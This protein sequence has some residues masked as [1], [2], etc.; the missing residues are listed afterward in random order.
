MDEQVLL[1]QPLLW[2]PPVPKDFAALSGTT[3]P[4]MPLPRVGALLGIGFYKNAMPT[5]FP[6]NSNGFGRPVAN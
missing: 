1:T 6:L 4:R 5:A 3:A 2:N